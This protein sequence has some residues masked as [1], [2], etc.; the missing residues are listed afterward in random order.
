MYIPRS[1]K[2]VTLR[3]SNGCNYKL[4][5]GEVDSGARQA[6]VSRKCLPKHIP[7]CYVCVQEKRGGFRLRTGRTMEHA[8]LEVMSAALPGTSGSESSE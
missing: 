8:L 3:S 5:R 2:S 7:G 4:R 1:R 6:Q